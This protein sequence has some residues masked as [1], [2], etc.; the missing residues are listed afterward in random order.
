MSDPVQEQLAAE[1]DEAAENIAIR[2]YR[3]PRWSSEDL[4]RISKARNN[5]IGSLARFKLAEEGVLHFDWDS[6][7][8][9]PG[10]DPEGIQNGPEY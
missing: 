8:W 9:R 3:Q 6:G 7:F 1:V 2:L 4:T 5:S 10:P